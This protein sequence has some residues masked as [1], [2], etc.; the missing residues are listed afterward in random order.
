MIS[1]IVSGIV[2]GILVGLISKSQV[3]VSGPAAGLVAIVG[4]AITSLGFEAFLTAVVI[5]GLMQSALGIARAGFIVRFIP[6]SVISGLLAA[7]GMLLVLKQLPHLVGYEST[8]LGDPAIHQIVQVNPVSAFSRLFQHIHFGAAAIGVA[9]ALLLLV[10][11]HSKTL[12]SSRLPAPLAVVALGIGMGLLF[13]EWGGSWRLNA[14]C[15]VNV[16]VA[17]DLPAFLGCLHGPDFSQLFNPAVYVVGLTIAVVASLETLLNLEAVE[18]IDPQ[19][20]LAP[21]SLELLAQGVGNVVAGLIGGL[22]I[23][24]VVVRS[25]VN[26]QAGGQTRLSAIVHGLLL[27][28]CVALI[29]AWLNYIPLSSLAAILVVTGL[30]LAS[31]TLAKRMYRAGWSQFVPFLCTTAA[32]LLTDL[33]VGI[34]AGLAISVGF[35]LYSSLRRPARTIVEKHVGDDVFRIQLA[36]QVSFLNRAAL[37]RALDSVPAGGHLL[38]DAQQSN[39]IDPDVLELIRDFTSQTAPARRVSI[40][41]RGFKESHQL[42]DRVQYVDYASRDL[43]AAVAPEDV[44]MI[45]TEGNRRFRSG[46]R[47]TRDLGRQVRLTADSQ[48]PLAVVISCVDSRIPAELVFDLG[49]GDIFNVRMAGNVV[50]HDVIGSVEYACTLSGAKLVLVMGHT[51]CGA[52]R[53]AV[54]L[55]NGPSPAEAV[56]RCRHLEPITAQI[57]QSIPPESSKQHPFLS[58]ADFESTC[59]AVARENTLRMA[60]LLTSESKSLRQLCESSQLA[61]LGAMYNV[62]TGEVDFFPEQE[63]K[64]NSAPRLCA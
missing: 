51:R 3:S 34:L 21:P 52:V 37:I 5:A 48:H 26:I 12:K 49:I 29:P 19:K 63:D 14:A 18:K 58:A 22:P 35:I 39:Y 7:I 54:Q 10:W 16:P 6:S 30:K 46:E 20:R 36:D 47:L 61:V 31:P 55:A 1:G 62:A 56:S 2:G 23:T 4:A 64:E 60:S 15:L 59:D 43:Q 45:L 13:H 57:R 33:L 44:L 8:P 41:L 32:I 27:L 9:S 38:L 53:A 40:S 42:E 17:R 25:T 50:T 28:S 11:N 24:S